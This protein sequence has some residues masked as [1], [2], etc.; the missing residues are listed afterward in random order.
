MVIDGEIVGRA[1][2]RAAFIEQLAGDEI[3]DDGVIRNEP[4]HAVLDPQL[5]SRVETL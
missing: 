4:G 3:G 2:G 1:A 5:P